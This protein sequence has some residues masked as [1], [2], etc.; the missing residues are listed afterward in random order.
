[1]HDT[2]ARAEFAI[3]GAGAIGS[4]IGAHLARSGRD[5]LMLARGARA[6]HLVRFG[7]QIKGL[8]EFSVRV[9]VLA[10][11]SQ[12]RSADTLIVSTKT[13]ATSAALAD[14]RRSSVGV[15]FSIQNGLL[16]NEQL[17][18]VWGRDRVL[19]ALADTSGELTQAGEVLF[20][21]NEQLLIGE[22]SGAPSERAERLA[23]L[24]D[25]SGVRAGAV[26][27][28]QSFE[29]SKFA[30]WAGL[31]VLSVTTRVP[32]WQYLTDADSARVLVRIVREIG[33]LAASHRISLSDRA[34]L[35][36][37]T[38]VGASEESAV[39]VVRAVG[40]RFKADAPEHR[41]SSLQDLEAGRPI[42]VEETLGYA[43]RLA[44]EGGLSLPLLESFY[45]L[46]AAV[47]RIRRGST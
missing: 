23:R 33:A 45:S 46:V 24:I 25:S 28:I 13:Y 40:G 38:I 8:A 22:L 43:V 10:D 6:A 16:K 2:M 19:G 36:V 11:G 12:L 15:A 1:M 14:L 26:P 44:A 27:D 42:E 32:T 31:M 47:D 39:A 30:A 17:A 34:P 4:I 3:V 20:T 35:P 18:A 5:V 7:L 21:R 37:A 29:W 41:M 9:R